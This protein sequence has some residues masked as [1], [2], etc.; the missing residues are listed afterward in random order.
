MPAFFDGKDLHLVGAVGFDLFG[1]FFTHGEALYA[2][3]E[4]GVDRDLTIYLNSPGGLVFDAEGIASAIRARS[5]KTTVV[6][7]GMAMSSATII[8]CAATECVISSG[9]I[10]MI[11]EPGVSLFAANSDGLA[12][13]ANIQRLVTDTYVTAYV[14]KTGKPEA[15]IREWMKA[16]TYFGPDEAVEAGFADRKSADVVDFASAAPA[17]AYG[18]KQIF[19]HAPER[20]IARAREKNWTLH[21][22]K[23][24][25][26]SAAATRQNK[27]T[28]M[29]DDK[30]GG[31]T[32]AELERLRA[33]NATLKA[34]QDA[35][36]QAAKDAELAELRAERDARANADAI[37]ALDE[38]KGNE[39]QAK[40]LADAGV[41]AEKAKAIL[42]AAPKAESGGNDRRRL[43]GEGLTGGGAPSAKGDKS[44]LADAV[45]RTNKRR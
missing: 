35:D 33:E 12:S 22:A 45:A 42:A 27:E 38:A 24:G 21:A 40:A 30:K 25:G 39:V 23:E 28:S 32:T 10:V 37:M 31:D 43:N 36:T 13:A 5:G 11:H 4:A 14:Q 20:L 34:S 3:A 17:Y 44:V 1:D 26:P 7:A 19:A 15:Q 41:T 18:D 9:S 29:S 6:I 2:L 8:A 16:E